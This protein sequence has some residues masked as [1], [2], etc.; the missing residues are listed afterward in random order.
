MTGPQKPLRLFMVSHPRT[1]SNLFCKLFSEHPDIEPIMYPFLFVFFGG[2]DAQA[3]MTKEQEEKAVSQKYGE[4]LK[5]KDYQACL[6]KLEQ[7]IADAEAQG[8]IPMVKEHACFMTQAV[9]VKDLLERP[10]AIP[11]KPKMEDRM[12]DIPMEKRAAYTHLPYCDLT[13][14]KI[15]QSVMPDRLWKTFAPLIIIR[16]PAKQVGS[17]YQASRVSVIPASSPDFELGVSYKAPRMAFEYFRD[18]FANDQDMSNGTSGTA[19][20][21]KPTWPIVIDGDDIVND[22]EGLARRFCALTGI[23]HAGVIYE[24]QKVEAQDPFRAVFLG[25]LNKSEGVIKNESPKKPSIKE[26]AQKWEQKWGPEVAQELVQYAEKV[27]EDYEY[28][29]QFRL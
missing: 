12:I 13:A 2:T 22:T 8:K 23:D 5:Y 7:D 10:R 26:E 29:Y 3:T 15:N 11:P 20:G 17:Y 25:T 28:L 9:I 19:S 27:M 24:W 6:D 21:Q 4:G 16:H 14:P 1:A 18:L